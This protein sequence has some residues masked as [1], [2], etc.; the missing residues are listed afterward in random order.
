MSENTGKNPEDSFSVQ[1]PAPSPNE[2]VESAKI[3]FQEDLIEE[4]KK[5]LHRVLI[6]HP[7]HRRARA[8]LEQIHQSEYDGILKQ[9]G[10]VRPK[11][12]KLEDPD[13]VI[14]ALEEDLGL[15]GQDSDA[16]DPGAATWTHGA[17]TSPQERLDLGVA[18]FE[19][20]CFRDALIELEEGL[21]LIRLEQSELGPLGVSIAALLA[22]ALIELGEAFAAKSFLIPL[23]GE[24]ELSEDS[25]LPLFYLMGRTEDSLGRKAEARAW[26]RRV[27]DADPWFRDADFR[28]RID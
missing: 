4:A 5:V 11:K 18:F 7:D 25:K 2:E 8:L 20:G 9:A 16:P 3:L 6:A 26:Y 14:A 13:E 28:A 12:T 15:R 21:R 17:R 22:E 24:P 27:L 1:E 19:M 10:T 23:L